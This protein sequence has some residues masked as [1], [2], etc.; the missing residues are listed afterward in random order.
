MHGALFPL[1]T[2]TTWCLVTGE[3]LQTWSL[4]LGI[5][6]NEQHSDIIIG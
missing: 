1:Y 2:S 6:G 5:P 3:N 4:T